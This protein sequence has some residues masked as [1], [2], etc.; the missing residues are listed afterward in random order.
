M[1]LNVKQI[2]PEG[3]T[4]RERL[5][6]D[7]GE[8]P[9]AATDIDLHVER[10]DDTVYVRGD[11]SANVHMVCGRCLDEFDQVIE[12]P[13]ELAFFPEEEEEAVEESRELRAEEMGAGYYTEDE[14]DI[15]EV[16]AEHL[17][18]NLPIRPLC[19]ENCKGICPQCGANLNE[20]QC[21]CEKKNID[22]RMEGLK[23]F[24]KKGKE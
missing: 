5:D 14:I 15:A 9:P 17:V 2:P 4:L 20:E 13:L 16:V 6:V 24:L 11:V 10:I 12:F 18:L 1:K 3:L 19:D 21:G 8:G 7:T 22:P 23:K